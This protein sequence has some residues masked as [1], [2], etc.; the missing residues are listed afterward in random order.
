MRHGM[1][2]LTSCLAVALAALPLVLLEGGAAG[3]AGS[4]A[5]TAPAQVSA[6]NWTTMPTKA[7]PNATGADSGVSCVTSVFCLAVGN[8][9][10]PNTGASTSEL[11]NGST[12]SPL[13]MPTVTTAA[14]SGPPVLVDVSCIT[15]SFC[16]AAGYIYYSSEATYTSLIEQWNGSAWSVVQGAV[17]P[18]TANYLVAVSCTSTTF[19]VAAG[20]VG[21]SGPVNAPYVEQ[22]NGSTWTPTALAL[23]TGSTN[24][25]FNGLSCT[26]ATA[27]MAVGLMSGS[28]TKPLAEQ[29][30]GSSWTVTA[31]PPVTPSASYSLAAVSCA[32]PSFCAAVSGSNNNNVVHTWNGSAWTAATTVPTPTGGGFL[33]GVS[34]FSA[35][36]CTAVGSSGT[37]LDAPEA[38]T[39][40]G[41]TW[42]QATTPPGPPTST[43]VNYVGVDCL[44]N[45]ACVAVGVANMPSNTYLPIQVMAPIA[46]NG[47]RFVASDGGIF[48]YGPM[49]G[50]GAPFLGSMGGQHLNAP[51]VGMAT[52]PAGD[53]YYEVAADGGIFNFGSAQFYGSTG[54]IHLN[55]PIVGMAV[56]PDGG[57]YWLVAS[58]GGVFNYGDAAFYGSMGGQPL[59]KPIVG[60]ASTPD[61]SGYYEVASDGGIFSF[62]TG[63]AGPPFL[64]STGSI[65]LNKP[66][67]GMAVTPAGQYY[68]VASDGGI[69][70][71]PSNPS[72]PPFYGSTGAINLNKPVVGMTVT[73][74]GA[75][76][77]LGASDGGIFS[78]PSGAAGPPFFG[79]RGG[80]PLN[81]PI[82]GISG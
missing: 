13:T 51:I 62:P 56:T 68:L 36:S 46:R 8:N 63:A 4:H 5:L 15:T 28:G 37:G 72:G 61:G 64:G 50:G 1:R 35:T 45:W 22:W 2:V 60:I 19:C 77:Y 41:Q 7:T 34:C 79:S 82:V 18:T 9:F 43:V 73:A 38:L 21:P 80:Q 31:V 12:W 16:V 76:Y 11:W 3:A 32:G 48:S 20:G 14:N 54:S 67:V 58:D 59:N 65:T 53:G 23:P 78:F 42:S 6:S 49:S 24:A 25:Y 27:C 71:F 69:F 74:G 66:I 81:S 44:T 30:N 39:F 29:W 70:S 26:T 75:G 55:K 40:D 47:Y 17:A 52:M 57:G 33:S 10:Y